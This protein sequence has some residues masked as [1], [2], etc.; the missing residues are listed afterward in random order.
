MV[1]GTG[2]TLIYW[3]IWFF[4]E[5]AWVATRTTAGYYEHQNA[6]PIAD[7]FMAVV[8]LLGAIGLWQR[9]PSTLLWMLLAGSASLYLGFM[10][11]LYNLE[12]GVYAEHLKAGG[13]FLVEL[14]VNVL[15]FAIPLYGIAFAWRSRWDLLGAEGG[16]S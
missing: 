14:G 4:G 15:A 16:V 1:F 13:S 12:N 5:R 11:V 7:G 10:D 9:R 2:S 6:F 8:S 3:A